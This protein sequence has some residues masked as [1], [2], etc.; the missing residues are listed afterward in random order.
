MSATHPMEPFLACPKCGQ[1][2]QNARCVGCHVPY[3][4]DENGIFRLTENR[5]FYFR[6]KMPKEAL[7]RINQAPDILKTCYQVFKHELQWKYDFYALDQNRGVGTLLSRL[8][9]N[10]VALDYGAGWGN[11]TKFMAHFARHV[12]SM[13]MTYESLHFCQRT[14]PDNITFL[15]G[16]DGALLPFRN[17][18]LDLVVLNG[19]LEW[20]PEYLTKGDPREVQLA[21]LRNIR[22]IL[23][24]DGQ[25][26]IGIEHR[27]GLV[28]FLGLP[29]EHTEIKYGTILPRPLANFVSRHKFN[30]PYRTYTYGKRGYRELLE[31][32]GFA[33][34]GFDIP[35]PDYRDIAAIHLLDNPG[36]GQ[37][38]K[39]LKR[40]LPHSYL[41]RTNARAQ[42]LLE[43]IL[44]ANN[45][46]RQAVRSIE[47][48]NQKSTLIVKTQST[49][50]KIPTSQNAG[51]RLR[52][53]A[54]TVAQLQRDPTLGRFILPM[55]CLE[56]DGL[57]VQAIPLVPTG[58]TPRTHDLEIFFRHQRETAL[59]LP[60]STLLVY[61]NVALFL[62]Y[63]G[64]APLLEQIRAFLGEQPVPCARM[65]GDLHSGHLLSTPEGLKI[66][67]WSFHAPR[68][69]LHSDHL[70]LMV[71]EER[72]RTGQDEVTVLSRLLL[73][74]AGLSPDNPFRHHAPLLQTL[75]TQVVLLYALQHLENRMGRFQNIAAIF[76]ASNQRFLQTIGLIE[77]FVQKI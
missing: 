64:R 66:I 68:Q 5:D 45:E 18:S 24:P 69:P 27:Y 74:A 39:G 76:H 61:P 17:N 44:A 20:L 58:Q 8:N 52:K 19:V 57:P 10:T 72:F 42:S 4:R 16:G 21:F 11:L 36:H 14:G 32:A 38:L 71:S 63:N 41:I 51:A 56:V 29:D 3:P 60:A 77:R 23:K 48:R 62:E 73:D 55:R 75:P 22:N 7:Q 31:E 43:T 50:Y 70:H 34:I 49:L 26:F 40:L 1:A 25:L 30:K 67:D 15:H 33:D 37:Q 13:D 59:P 35:D 46:S 6:E 65:H 2:L 47:N 28:Y 9:R 53:E 54:D 12:F